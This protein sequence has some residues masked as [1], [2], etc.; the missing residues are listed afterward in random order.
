MLDKDRIK[1]NVRTNSSLS[2]AHKKELLRLIDSLNE[3]LQ[4]SEIGNAEQEKSISRINKVMP[5]AASEGKRVGE[6]R[7]AVEVFETTHPKI[8]M[9]IDRICRMLSDSGI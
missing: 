5:A 7:E 6:I 4:N 2:D 1:N 8:T 9:L 3:E